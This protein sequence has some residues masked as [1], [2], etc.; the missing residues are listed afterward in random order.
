[1]FH[2]V[3][4]QHA[5][6]SALGILVPPGTKTLVIVR[7]RALEWDLLPARWD[8][9]GSHPP[10][11]CLFTRDEA[12]NVA[13]RVV[14]SLEAAVERGVSPLESFGDMQG[15]RLQIWLRTDELV[16]IV[17]KR[18]QGQTY[19]PLTFATPEEATHIA[20]QL[21]PYVWPAAEGKQEYYFNTQK[22]S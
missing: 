4:P 2:R 11:F 14:K 21:A 18:V 15:G 20:D 7:P 13:R 17:C 9:D 5:G 19:L 3:E 1:L 10:E 16:W 6:P 12:A 8:G 22:F